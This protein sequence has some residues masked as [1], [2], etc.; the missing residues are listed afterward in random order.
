VRA[1]ATVKVKK[2]SAA[3]V[4]QFLYVKTNSRP[5]YLFFLKVTLMR[6]KCLI[7]RKHEEYKLV[8]H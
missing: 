3:V 2:T 7:E 6:R 4:A 5:E 8:V 1:A